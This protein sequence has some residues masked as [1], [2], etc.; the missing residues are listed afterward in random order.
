MKKWLLPA[1]L[2]FLFL[3]PGL[4][5]A[6]KGGFVFMASTIGPIDSGIVGALEDQFEKDT[7]DR[8]GTHMAELGLWEKTGIKPAGAW[9]RVYEKGV[10][11]K[12]PHPSIYTDLAGGLHGH[13]PGHI[14]AV[15]KEIQDRRPRREGRGPPSTISA[16]SPSIRRRSAM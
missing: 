10:R 15:Q 3:V 9:Y 4:C 6:Q 11:G 13:R 8:S 12:H 7:G 16:L 5:W 1:L 2:S 14:L